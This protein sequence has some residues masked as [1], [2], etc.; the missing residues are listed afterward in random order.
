MF[1][2][3]IISRKK[4]AGTIL[5]FG[6]ILM[7]IQFIA[8]STG[9]LSNYIETQ[10]LIAALMLLFLIRDKFLHIEIIIISILFYTFFIGLITYLQY[11]GKIIDLLNYFFGPLLFVATPIVIKI[12]RRI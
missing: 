5:L 6:P 10:P 4:L 1:N 8:P 12:N 11:G 7:Y 9:A 3:S 2:N